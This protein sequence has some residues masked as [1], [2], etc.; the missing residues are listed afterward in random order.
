MKKHGK[1]D[2]STCRLINSIIINYKELASNFYMKLFSF[3]AQEVQKLLKDLK[4]KIQCHHYFRIKSP[5]FRFKQ[6]LRS[7]NFPSMPRQL[8]EHLK[9]A[10][11]ILGG[12]SFFV[13]FL[14]TF[15]NYCSY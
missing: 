9:V 6:G 14:F 5:F 8:F 3:A 11:I 4:R 1:H 2:R 10:V 13:D 12:V 7:R 15:C